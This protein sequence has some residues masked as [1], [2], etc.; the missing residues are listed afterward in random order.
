MIKI[1]NVT[2]D[3]LQQCANI[4]INIYNN[5]SLS[6][7]WTEKSALNICEFYFK[8]QPDLFFVAKDS[9]QCA[10]K[11]LGFTFSFIKPW[12]D[13]NQLMAEELA[14]LGKFRKQGIASKLLKALVKT[15][16]EK[17]K[18]TAVNGTTY[19]SETEMPFMWYK[20]IGFTKVKDLYLIEAEPNNV[21]D[22][23]KN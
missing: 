13:G 1:I 2:K 4:L 15:A 16:V 10:G 8:L 14:V 11:V 22:K 18:I 5:N 3:E 9:S 17:Y 23:I 21:L 12:A 6:E 7:G 20:K 19:N